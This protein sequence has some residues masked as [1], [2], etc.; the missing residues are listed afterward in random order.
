MGRAKGA[1]L[2]SSVHQCPPCLGSLLAHPQPTLISPPSAAP[3]PQHFRLGALVSGPTPGACSCQALGSE[4][5]AAP[6]I[7]L[8]TSAGTQS[9]W[10]VVFGHP[11]A[12][13][14]PLYLISPPGTVKRKD[15][16]NVLQIA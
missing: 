14:S 2:P 6:W 10:R 7:P 8:C 1:G 5:G 3:A 4:P 15:S 12:G 13:I 11:R 9:H 16:Q